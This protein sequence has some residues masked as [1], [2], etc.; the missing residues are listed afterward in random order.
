MPFAHVTV[1]AEDWASLLAHGPFDLL[2]LDGGGSGKAPGDAA[3]DPRLALKPF[4]TLVIDDFTPCTSWPPAHAGQV[5]LARLHWSQ[6]PDLLATE[7]VLCAGMSTIV[8]LR[9]G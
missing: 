9:R 4:G 5:D 3:V 1:L 6:H 2:V 7:V 8:A